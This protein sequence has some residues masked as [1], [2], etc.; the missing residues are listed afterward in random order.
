MAGRQWKRTLVRILRLWRLFQPRLVAERKAAVYAISLGWA[1]QVPSGLEGEPSGGVRIA[2]NRIGTDESGSSA[3][4]NGIGVRIGGA[5]VE[6][7]VGGDSPASGN[8]I[9][10][11]RQVIKIT[12]LPRPPMLTYTGFPSILTYNN[13]GLPIDLRPFVSSDSKNST[14]VPQPFGFS[15]TGGH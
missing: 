2:G 5:S 11:D 13:N 1:A 12:V 8:L 7:V 10:K 4:P 6:T 15:A 9:A 14:G 3:I